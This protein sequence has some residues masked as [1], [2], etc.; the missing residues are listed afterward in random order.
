MT[1]V[2]EPVTSDVGPIQ[3][4]RG[5][6][7]ADLNVTADGA[8]WADGVEIG[9]FGIV[10]FQN[11]DALI[12]TS[13]TQFEAPSNLAPEPSESTVL[14]GTIEGSNASI[15]HEMVEMIIGMRQFEAAQQALKSISDVIQQ[16]T[17]YDG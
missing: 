6:S 16:F 11:Q 7:L 4:P 14:Q 2:G 12:Q 17:T 9:N 3:L 13:S 10:D 8:I 1:A 15:V 5:A